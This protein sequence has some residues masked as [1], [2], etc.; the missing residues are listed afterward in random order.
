MPTEALARA[1]T[2]H[3][4]RTIVV[5]LLGRWN[6]YLPRWLEWLPRLQVEAPAR[7]SSEP[8]R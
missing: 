6:W 8:A 3:P 7:V 5:H 2:R 4:W 1:S